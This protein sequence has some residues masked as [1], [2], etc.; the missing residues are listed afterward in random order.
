MF[1][2][3]RMERFGGEAVNYGE[4]FLQFSRVGK[5]IVYRNHH[6]IL[7]FFRCGAFSKE[8]GNQDY[9][10]MDVKLKL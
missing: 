5:L 10:V 2:P 9:P 1:Y 8:D 7:I 3:L 4:S 6:L